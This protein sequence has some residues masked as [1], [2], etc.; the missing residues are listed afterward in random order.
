MPL[1]GNEAD[2]GEVALVLAIT[3]D[4]LIY[5]FNQT[6]QRVIWREIGKQ[7]ELAEAEAA[8]LESMLSSR[9]NLS[10]PP[11]NGSQSIPD[12]ESMS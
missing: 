11:T 12:S 4:S 6:V 1:I 5:G 9:R 10:H 3:F 7:L 8:F 2:I